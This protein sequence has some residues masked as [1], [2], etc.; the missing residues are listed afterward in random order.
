M[1]TEFEARL[2]EV[3]TERF[4]TKLKENNAEFIGEWDQIRKCYDINPSDKSTWI[5]LRKYVLNV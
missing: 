1:K 5:R 4:I 3:D 2:L